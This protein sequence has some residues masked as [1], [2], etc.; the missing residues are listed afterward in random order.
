MT[1]GNDGNA[2]QPGCSPD[3]ALVA[4]F[5]AYRRPRR[6]GD[7]SI[8]TDQRLLARLAPGAHLE[9]AR[10]LYAGPEG[11]MDLVPGAGSISFL[12]RKATGESTCGQTT[13]QLA[14]HHGLGHTRWSREEG[15]ILAGA[16]AVGVRLSVVATDG[17][18]IAVPVNIDGA[19]WFDAHD[20][21]EAVWSAGKDILNR[22]ALT[23]PQLNDF[24]RLG[25][26]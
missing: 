14:A 7:D 12:A 16:L 21:T 1:S 6:P 18:K 4:A 20:A 9:L 3:P 24:R 23:E 10:R 8:K 25:E 22:S 19:Y 13:T 5:A 2:E 26:D 15:Y 17:S 11:T